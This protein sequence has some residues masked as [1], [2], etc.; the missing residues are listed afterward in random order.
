MIRK[1]LE[2]C[3]DSIATYLIWSDPKKLRLLQLFTILVRRKKKHKKLDLA[4]MEIFFYHP[5]KKTKA[6]S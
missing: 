3:L 4:Q 5:T 6:H 1:K 2:P